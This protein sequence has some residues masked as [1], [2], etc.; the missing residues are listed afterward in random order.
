MTHEI[1]GISQAL[2]SHSA[3]IAGMKD[4]MVLNHTQ[5]DKKLDSVL[6]QLVKLNGRVAKSEGRLD[7]IEPEVADYKLGKKRALYALLGLGALGG[8]GGTGLLNAIKAFLGVA[9]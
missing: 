5:M 4:T 1:D 2:G 9:S 6:E 8:A 3:Q 7:D